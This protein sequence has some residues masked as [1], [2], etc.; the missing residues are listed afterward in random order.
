MKKIYVCYN[1][2]QY[3]REE[4]V[5]SILDEKYDNSYKFHIGNDLEFVN[6]VDE[7]WTFGDCAE[8]ENYKKAKELGLD[9][10]VMA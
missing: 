2:T 4:V 8:M 9:I 6:I 5:K 10:W 7:F 1:R 3:T